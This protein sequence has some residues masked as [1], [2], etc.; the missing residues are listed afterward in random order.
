MTQDWF[1]SP[2]INSQKPQMGGLLRY[3]WASICA[4]TGAGLL[5]GLLIIVFDAIGRMF[6]KPM[7]T[8]AL[9]FSQEFSAI[10]MV[11][12]AYGACGLVIGSPIVLL[13]APF[14]EYLNKSLNGNLQIFARLVIGAL[15]GVFAA[16]ALWLI[17][18]YSIKSDFGLIKIVPFQMLGNG[19]LIGAFMLVTFN[20]LLSKLKT[21]KEA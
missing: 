6:G 12:F 10:I 11:L 5:V 1:D 20:K 16:Y 21:K 15:G 17:M 18:I 2:N 3:V 19:A 4:G 9:D 14:S 13:L 8:P 7:T